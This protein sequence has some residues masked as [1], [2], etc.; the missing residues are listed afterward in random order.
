MHPAKEI[1]QP[2]SSRPW[3]AAELRARLAAIG[4]FGVALVAVFAVSGCRGAAVTAHRSAS[5]DHVWVAVA[6]TSQPGWFASG[7]RETT[8]L[9]ERR[10]Q[11]SNP[12]DSLWRRE[13]WLP[14][15]VLRLTHRAPFPSGGEFVQMRWLTPTHLQVRYQ[16]DTQVEYHLQS[17]SGIH[18]LVEELD[19][20]SGD[21]VPS[22]AVPSDGMPDDAVHRHLH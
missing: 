8:V 17:C 12:V 19:Q 2:R 21:E 6:R 1:S 14:V 18:I 22:H 9:L 16:G 3:S 7:R 20:S 4:A 10:K 15:T 5:P 13:L 11:H